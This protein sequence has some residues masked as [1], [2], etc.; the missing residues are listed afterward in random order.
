MTLIELLSTSVFSFPQLKIRDN[1]MPSKRIEGL[2]SV[3][4]C[5]VLEQRN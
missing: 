4:D 2:I 5:E 3:E 1:S